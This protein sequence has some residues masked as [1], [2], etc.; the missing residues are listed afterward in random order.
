MQLCWLCGG[1]FWQMPD[2]GAVKKAGED[3]MILVIGGAYQG[4]LDFARKTYGITSGW[5][6][7]RDCELS[8][9]VSCR[10]IHHFHDYMRRITGSCY[11]GPDS[12]I[13]ADSIGDSEGPGKSESAGNSKNTGKPE[14]K[15]DSESKRNSEDTGKSQE[16]WRS[17]S[18][19]SSENNWDLKDIWDFREEDLTVLENQADRFASWLF[20]NNPDII[21][22]S[23]ELGYGIVPMEKQDRLWRE[24]TGR[25]CTCLAARANEVVRVVCGI[26]TW[27]KYLSESYM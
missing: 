6:D 15:W 26:G 16:T 21:I 5:I 12:V 20:E 25:V 24:T 8:Q 13:V 27:L 19:R 14:S 10:G 7:G 9:I 17:E 22:V 18:T 23:N 2:C 11:C 3:E 1:R 4:K